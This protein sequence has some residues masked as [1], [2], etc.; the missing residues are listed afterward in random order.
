MSGGNRIHV[1]F[2]HEAETPERLGTIDVQTARGKEIFVFEFD[3]SW[4]KH[5]PGR[6]LDPDLQL[7]PGPQFS[8]KDSFGI[9][10][11]SAPDRWGRRLILRREAL[12]AEKAGERPRVLRESDF[13]L[14]VYDETRMGALRFKTEEDGPFLNDDGRMAAPPWARL[15]D[16]E[17]ACRKLD[18]D[19]EPEEHEKWL[20]LLIAPGS[21]LGGARPKATVAAPDGTLW[22]AKFPSHNDAFNISAWEYAVM[23]MAAE[24]GL[25]V[26]ECRRENFSRFGSSFLVKRFDRR[27]KRRI[28]FS[29][30][31]TLLGKTDGSDFQ[32][33][34]SYLELAEFIMRFG[35][36]PERDLRELWR[37]IVFSIA[38]SNTDD[39]LRN[40][41]FLLSGSGWRLSP[42]YD[43]NPNPQGHGLSLNISESDNALDFSLALENAHSFRLSPR[44]AEDTLKKIL[45]VVSH[46]RTYAGL[47]GIPRGEQ[48]MMQTAFRY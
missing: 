5:H 12:R 20:N 26:P 47:A 9:F 28:H 35:A 48:E 33:G 40:H 24:C 3:R 8:Q 44:E 16:L 43:I 39:H 17:E 23:R 41:G 36:E 32:D 4:L 31:M 37:R 34:S 6:V 13:L 10:M 27:G 11:D 25:D 22:I 46:W 1:Y 29:S 21:S 7:Y 42:A 14:G 30:A 19:R 18:D 38:V 45:G 15:R 2:D